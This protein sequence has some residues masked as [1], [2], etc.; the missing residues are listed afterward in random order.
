MFFLL[1]YHL[2]NLSIT[3]SWNSFFFVFVFIYIHLSASPLPPFISS[4]PRL[5]IPS[6][7]LLSSTIYHSFSVCSSI[8]G[9]FSLSS[10]SPLQL[11]SSSLSSIC[12]PSLFLHVLCSFLFLFLTPSRPLPLS[13]SSSLLLF[14]SLFFP[15]FLPP[16]AVFFSPLLF[17]LAS[18][19]SRSYPL[20]TLSPSPSTFLPP[21]L[22][23]SSLPILYFSPRLIF[24]LSP[25][26][27][28]SPISSSA[29]FF[30]PRLPPVS[31]P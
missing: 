17:I 7:L 14:R 10:S 27:L 19:P 29:P 9:P 11:I 3:L 31:P 6:Y 25:F 23:S 1:F 20:S 18:L 28:F 15:V 5:H 4:L 22:P 24:P 16:L 12:L 8:L 21:S 26:Y 2:S 30:S 13:L